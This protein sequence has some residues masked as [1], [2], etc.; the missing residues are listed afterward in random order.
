MFNELRP[1]AFRGKGH[2]RVSVPG[3]VDEIETAVYTVEVDRLRATGC[4]TG[5]RQPSLPC[6]CVNQT[7]FPDVA[8]TQKRYLGQPVGGEL[9]GTT[10][11]IDEFCYQFHY[12]GRLA[13]D[14][15]AVN[16]SITCFSP[17]RFDRP[18]LIWRERYGGT[19]EV[20]LHVRGVRCP[21]QRKNP[22]RLRKP[23]NDLSGR[24]VMAFGDGGEQRVA[25]GLRIGCQQRE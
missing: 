2:P 24:G 15:G 3:Q 25:H 20:L 4:I 17:K 18:Q 21:R 1:L 11:T 9:L 6:K 13:G 16:N 23:E 12:T 8:S 22:D 5:K 7:G 14:K 19:G 10:G